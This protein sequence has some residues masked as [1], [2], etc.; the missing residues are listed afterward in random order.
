MNLRIKKGSR[1]FSIT[2]LKCPRCQ[3]GDLFSV[4]N[5][6]NLRRVLDMP[7]RCPTCHQDFKI[8]PGFYSGALWISYPVILVLIVPSAL[9]LLFA[10]HFPILWALLLPFTL[11]LALQPLIMRFCRAIWLNCFV[12]YDDATVIAD[13]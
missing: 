4:S 6:Y 8:E 9:I 5:P 3:Q 13:T 11:L 1:S 7:G 10:F 2:H 12:S